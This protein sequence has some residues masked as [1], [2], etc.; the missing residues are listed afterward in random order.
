VEWFH[1][2][3]QGDVDLISSKKKRLRKVLK[4]GKAN[5]REN[6]LHASRKKAGGCYDILILLLRKC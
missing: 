4:C 1:S 6:T 3:Q 2:V 5:N